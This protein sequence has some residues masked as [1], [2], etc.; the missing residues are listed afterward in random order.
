[1][2][3]GG[4]MMTMREA[5]EFA[6]SEIMRADTRLKIIERARTAYYRIIRYRGQ[7]TDDANQTAA[8]E[9]I[10]QALSE[11]LMDLE[12]ESTRFDVTYH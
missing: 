12:V 2:R 7:V 5:A 1:M 4:V 9:V 8:E 11:R 3:R 10:L 6:D